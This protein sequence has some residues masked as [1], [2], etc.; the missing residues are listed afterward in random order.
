M[1]SRHRSFTEK[2]TGGLSE[3]DESSAA[4]QDRHPDQREPEVEAIAVH[5]AA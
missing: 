1:R 2:E 3:Q 4:H 5:R